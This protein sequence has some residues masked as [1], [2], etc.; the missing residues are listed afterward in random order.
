MQ[1][2][3]TDGRCIY[4]FTVIPAGRGGCTDPAIRAD[5]PQNKT[6]KPF[7]FTACFFI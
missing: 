6:V 1:H 7:G 3:W 5:A 2:P 4:N